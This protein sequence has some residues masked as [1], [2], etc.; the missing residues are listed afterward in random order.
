MGPDELD[1]RIDDGR[2]DILASRRG[3]SGFRHDL[4]AQAAAGGVG[5]EERAGL[6]I[7]L[8]D[9]YAQAGAHYAKARHRLLASADGRS[10]RRRRSRAS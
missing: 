7:A 2:A 10:D 6:H 3:S 9:A 1:R 8:A 5:A 4:L